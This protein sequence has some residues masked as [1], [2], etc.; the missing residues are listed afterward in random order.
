MA[1][2]GVESVNPNSIPTQMN[3]QQLE[4]FCLFAV[5]VAGKGA[6]QTEAKLNDY[7]DNFG[8]FGV[9]PFDAV[10]ADI[11]DG[12]LGYWIR[13]HRFGQ[14]TRIEKAWTEL[15][16]LDVTK[17]LTVEKLEAIPG[18]G[19][20]TARFIVLYTQ[21]DSNVVPLDTHILKY[22]A[23]RFPGV[24]VPKSTP[25]KGA[26]YAAL[27][28]LFQQEAKRRKMTVKELDTEVWRSYAIK[29]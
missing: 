6:K 17:D 27:E 26:K 5:A 2:S 23:K 16:K 9:N 20:K 22:L 29:A 24:A 25:S 11:Y 7:M 13:A 12:V 4:W 28:Q 21:P 1:S 14:Y 19:P 8:R 15:V 18:I 10:R 3:R